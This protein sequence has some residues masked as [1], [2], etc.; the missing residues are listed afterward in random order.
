MVNKQLPEAADHR[1]GLRIHSIFPTIQ[2]EGPLAGRPA[3]FVRLFGCNLRCPGCDTDYTSQVL[4]DRDDAA[5]LNIILDKI[6]GQSFSDLGLRSVG[7]NLRP[8]VVI[9]GGEPLRQDIRPLCRALLDIG[10]QVQ[11]ES[12]GTID[13]DMSG[14]VPAIYQSGRLDWPV[15][16]QFEMIISPKTSTLSRTAYRHGTAFKYILDHRHVSPLDG[17]PT[18][19]L[20]MNQAP[21]RPPVCRVVGKAVDG[22][23]PCSSERIFL[24]HSRRIFLD[25]SRIYVQPF[26]AKDDKENELNVQAA[27]ESCMKYGYT[28]SLQSHKI[29]NLP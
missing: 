17:L 5:A 16:L 10:I 11:I 14:L 25:H 15:S 23:P 1:P 24:D 19:S 28:L 27:V 8:L 3:V 6:R 29:L 12:N 13:L 2:G 21:A 22:P 26:D 4:I 18:R 20:S 9:T 7:Q